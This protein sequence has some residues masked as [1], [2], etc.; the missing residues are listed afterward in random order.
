MA[1]ETEK[2]NA[3]MIDL[4]NKFNKIKVKGSGNMAE[5]YL[6][7]DEEISSSVFSRAIT[8]KGEKKKKET[9]VFDLDE[10]LNPKEDLD[11]I[12]KAFDFFIDSQEDK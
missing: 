5:N 10:V 7:S 12:M 9:E 3:R 2:E 4:S 8:R 1:A 11:E 6:N